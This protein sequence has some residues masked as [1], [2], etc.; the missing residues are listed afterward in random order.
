MITATLL[1]SAKN[2]KD[3]TSDDSDPLLDAILWKVDSN[4]G[5]D[6]KNRI[7]TKFITESYRKL[8]GGLLA[9]SNCCSFHRST[10]TSPSGL[11]RS[12]VR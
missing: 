11:L 1:V 4:S 9:P 8:T 6:C 12:E 7:L 5:I 2:R 3:N 10:S